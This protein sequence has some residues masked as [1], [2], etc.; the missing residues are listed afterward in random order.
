MDLPIIPQHVAAVYRSGRPSRSASIL[1]TEWPL[2]LAAGAETY[3]QNRS[4]ALVMPDGT[5]TAGYLLAACLAMQQLYAE[6]HV[7]RPVTTSQMD[8]AAA[9]E[10]RYQWSHGRRWRRPEAALYTSLLNLVVERPEKFQGRA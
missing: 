2:T 6:K 10:I 3:W 9:R 4:F 5:C 1:A 7:H 8:R